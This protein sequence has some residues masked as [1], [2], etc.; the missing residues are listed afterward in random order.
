[1]LTFHQPIAVLTPIARF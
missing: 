1:M